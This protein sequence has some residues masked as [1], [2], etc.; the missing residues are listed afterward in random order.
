MRIVEGLRGRVA[1]HMTEF[2]TADGAVR[3]IDFMP[4]RLERPPRGLFPIGPV[5][6]DDAA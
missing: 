1:M 5:V 4:R 2:G 3:L 6:V